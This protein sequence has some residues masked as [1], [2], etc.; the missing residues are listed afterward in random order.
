MAATMAR[1]TATSSNSG[2]LAIL[3]SYGELPPWSHNQ[4]TFQAADAEYGEVMNTF[5]VVDVSIPVT[6]LQDPLYF[7]PLT[8]PVLWR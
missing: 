2:I 3:T 4:P 8:C 7:R 5:A 6:S 1:G